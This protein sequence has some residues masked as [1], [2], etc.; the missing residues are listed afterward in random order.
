MAPG[1]V[2]TMESSPVTF[3]PAT[4]AMPGAGTP[5]RLLIL[6]DAP[7]RFAPFAFEADFVMTERE[8]IC[9]L[10]ARQSDY[11]AV[12]AG[13]AEVDGRE[14]GYRLAQLLRAQMQ[15]RCPIYL[16]SRSPTPSSRA[17]ALQCGATKL[18]TDDQDLVDDLVLLV[19]A[20]RTA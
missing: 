14:C 8:A 20:K 5:Q 12:I 13:V 4:P 6:T 1:K 19:G 16:F 10:A 7:E 17:Y 15:M 3:T 11:R 2:S 18:L 9:M